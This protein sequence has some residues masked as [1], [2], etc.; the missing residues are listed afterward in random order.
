MDNQWT[1]RGKLVNMLIV[2]DEPVICEGLR[3]TIDWERLGVRVVDVAYDGAE[4]LRLVGERD[5]SVVLSDIRMEGMDGLELAERLKERFP[6]VRIVMISGYEDFEYARQ[7]IRL[8]VSDYLLKPVDIDELT[9]VVKAIVEGVRGRERDG[10]IQEA[11]LWLSNMARQGTAYGKEAPPSLHGAEFRVLA[12]QMV[13]FMERFGEQP[14]EHY[15]EIQDDWVDRL[16]A[17]LRCPFL[18]LISVFD[19]ENLLYTLIVSEIRMDLAAWDRLLEAAEPVLQKAGIC[20]GASGPYGDLTETGE[21][22]AEAS[23]LL[24]YHLLE[25]KTVLLPDYPRT[26]GRGPGTA[27]A[28]FD[29][30][31]AARNLMAAMLKRDHNELDALVAE[32]FAFF[33]EKRFLPEELWIAYEELAVLIR[34]RMR[35]SGQTGLDD[36]HLASPDMNH[37]NSYGSLERLVQGHMREWLKFIERSGMDK[38]Y[39][40][41]EKAKKYMNEHYRADL[42]ASELASWLKITPSYFSYIFKQ[43]TGKGFTEYMNE[44]RMEHAKEL[45]ATT[46]DKVFEIADKVGYKEYKYFVSVFKTYTGMTPKEYRGLSAA[47][48][49]G[50]RVH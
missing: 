5:V 19:H 3:R 31:A 15:D 16:H 26:A 14:P 50:G 34:Q 48:D 4:A 27:T 7:A 12:T 43:S 33:R 13:R 41:I 38:S 11:K 40:I 23:R 46:H 6:N 18:R 24:P 36:V 8:G 10:G 1:V 35:R 25:N 29:A 30:E 45:L 9:E 21:R 2:D 32:M 39:W 17:E 49:A 20:C 28:D 22:C 37:F 42:K 44:M 47:R